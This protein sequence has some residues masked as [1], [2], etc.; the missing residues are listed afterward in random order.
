MGADAGGFFGGGDHP[1]VESA[2]DA[3]AL[4][5]V[6]DDYIANKVAA[7]EQAGAHGIL[8]REHAVEDESH[9]VVFKEL[10][11]CEHAARCRSSGIVREIK[12]SGAHPKRIRGPVPYNGFRALAPGT[13]EGI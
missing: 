7:G 8:V 6:F 13:G 1:L 2:A 9:V 4:D 3:A 10:G 11:D 5:R 12:P